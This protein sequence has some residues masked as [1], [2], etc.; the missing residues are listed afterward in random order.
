MGPTAFEKWYYANLTTTLC[1]SD[2]GFPKLTL[3]EFDNWL[4]S[5]INKSTLQPFLFIFFA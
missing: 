4:E 1:I 3:I 5:K 2:H